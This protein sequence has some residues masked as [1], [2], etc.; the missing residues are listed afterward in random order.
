MSSERKSEDEA[1][2]PTTFATINQRRRALGIAYSKPLV[3]SVGL[4]MSN[5]WREMHDR[6]PGGSL[7]PKENGG[8]THQ[9]RGYPLWFWP[10]ID[11]ALRAGGGDPDQ[12]SLFPED[13]PLADSIGDD[14][15]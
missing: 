8:G 11:A 2:I 9:I 6:R 15:P 12:P 3:W 13:G 1:A 5:L 7:T 10:R 14:G 4:A